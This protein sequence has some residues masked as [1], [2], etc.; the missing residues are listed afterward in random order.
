MVMQFDT[1]EKAKAWYNRLCDLA[2]I[3]HR[4]KG[5]DYRV[6]IVEGV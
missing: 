3:P 1:P 2:A 6:Y 4:Q 5:A